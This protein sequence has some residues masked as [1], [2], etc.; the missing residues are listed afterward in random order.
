VSGQWSGR[1]VT[2]ARAYWR[3]RII[4]AGAL[5]C[6]RPGCGRM[7]TVESAWTVGHIVDRSRGGSVTDPAN[8]WPECKRCNLSAGGR[9]GAAKTNARRTVVVAR[10]SSEQSR[11]IRGW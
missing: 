1:R 2:T 5:P 8:Q 9:L 4:E 3:Q 7:L 10:M 6:W 11:G